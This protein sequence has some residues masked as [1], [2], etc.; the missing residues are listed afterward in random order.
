MNYKD[1]RMIIAPKQSHHW[2]DS[3]VAMGN[4]HIINR[5]LCRLMILQNW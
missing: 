3:F 1:W 2:V 4:Q 5:L